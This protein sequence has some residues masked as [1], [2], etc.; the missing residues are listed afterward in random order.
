[1]SALLLSFFDTEAA[2]A[3]HSLVLANSGKISKQFKT[4]GLGILVL[5]F[6]CKRSPPTAV[7]CPLMPT[8]GDLVDASFPS[9]PTAMPNCCYSLQT[10]PPSFKA[11]LAGVSMVNAMTGCCYQGQPVL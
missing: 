10:L 9:V 7:V 1:M 2:S 8:S 3:G 11:F 6:H 4:E 5:T